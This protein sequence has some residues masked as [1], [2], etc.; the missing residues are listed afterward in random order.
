MRC[1]YCER[2]SPTDICWD[3]ICLI[4]EAVRNYLARKGK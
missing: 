4:F 3:C 2:E 1:H